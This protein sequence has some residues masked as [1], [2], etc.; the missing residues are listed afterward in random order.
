MSI[1]WRVEVCI[2]R[3]HCTSPHLFVLSLIAIMLLSA[4]ATALFALP[5]TSALAV[6]TASD[7]LANAITTAETLRELFYEDSIG[8]WTS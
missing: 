3:A 5:M 4:V 6:R 2:K 1:S 7:Y 8:L